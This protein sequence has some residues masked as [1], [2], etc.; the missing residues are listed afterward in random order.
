M[1]ESVQAAEIFSL[2]TGYD[3]GYTIVCTFNELVGDEIDL[4]VYTGS[5]FL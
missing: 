1:C 4:T 3:A 5:P 2:R